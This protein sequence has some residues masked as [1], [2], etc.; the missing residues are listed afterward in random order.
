M[1]EDETEPS[2]ARIRLATLAD[3]R[4]IA[5]FAEQRRR[6]Y[7]PYQPVFWRVAAD[8]TARHESYLARQLSHSDA[9]AFVHQSGDAI[10]AF[11]IGQITSAPPVYDPG[12]PV[13]VVDDF[14][15][16]D[17][18][19]WHDVGSALLQHV[20]TVARQE[21]GCVVVIVVCGDHDKPKQA[22]LHRDGG[23]IASQWWIKQ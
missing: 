12:G 9:L 4:Q 16:A 18:A 10:D 13:C 7:E 23:Q 14:M 15:V 6:D 11:I 3:V 8:A 21:R 19:R 2:A 20:E 5:A 17:A 22:M 1:A